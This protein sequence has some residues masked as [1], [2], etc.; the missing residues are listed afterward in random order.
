MSLLETFDLLD[1]LRG[2]FWKEAVRQVVMISFG[3]ALVKEIRLIFDS[4]VFIIGI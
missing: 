3:L 2:C 4:N 1:T